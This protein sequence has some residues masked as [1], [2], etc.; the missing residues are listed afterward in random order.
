MS[1]TRHTGIVDVAVH[2]RAN[3]SGPYVVTGGGGRKRRRSNQQLLL[4]TLACALDPPL[5]Q[6]NRLCVTMH[7]MARAWPSAV[8]CGCRAVNA[9]Q[10]VRPR[11][12]AYPSEWAGSYCAI[13]SP[14]F[15]VNKHTNAARDRLIKAR[16]ELA[17]AVD[18]AVEGQLRMWSGHALGHSAGLA[19]DG[20]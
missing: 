5:P 1:C 14:V 13:I 20:T 7:A 11:L 16:V 8:N 9:L 10:K 15:M 2:V 18:T 3:G 4:Q 19:V 12:S 17:A 6:I